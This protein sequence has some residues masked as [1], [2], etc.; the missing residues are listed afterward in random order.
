MCVCA[1]L[2]GGAFFLA[3]PGL[4]LA[5]EFV[6]NPHGITSRQFHEAYA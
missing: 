5:A 1:C 2:S 4:V 3:L 6:L